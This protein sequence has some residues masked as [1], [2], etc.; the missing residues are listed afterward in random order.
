MQLFWKSLSV[1]FMFGFGTAM[2]YI[3][4]HGVRETWERASL[5]MRGHR[6]RGVIVSVDEERDSDSKPV[7]CLTVEFIG[8]DG[9]RRVVSLP[10]RV[11]ARRRTGERMVVVYRPGDLGHAVA[12]APGRRVL[13]VVL[14]PILLAVGAGSFVFAV[15]YLL[16]F[17]SVTLFGRV[18][19]LKD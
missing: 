4:F 9:E 15:A 1:V 19:E 18:V 6:A 14:F 8:R 13:S 12:L 5:W 3:A 17:D 11:Y 2:M 10:D 16:D 7:Y